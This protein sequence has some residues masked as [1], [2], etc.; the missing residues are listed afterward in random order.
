MSQ[1]VTP[2]WGKDTLPSQRVPKRSFKILKAYAPPIIDTVEDIQ[3]IDKYDS[4]LVTIQNFLDCFPTKLHEL[5][6]ATLEET[7]ADDNSRLKKG[8]QDW[9]K[10]VGLKLLKQDG[11]FLCSECGFSTL[12]KVNAISHVQANHVTG[13]VGYECDESG[14][15]SP[16]IKTLETHMNNSHSV[17]MPKYIARNIIVK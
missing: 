8:P 11:S 16:T 12:T 1:A 9:D 6:K 7:C 4:E 15:V 5:P 3:K 13:F 10:D 17:S 14:K 2:T